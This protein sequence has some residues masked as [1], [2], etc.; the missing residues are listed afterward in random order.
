[1]AVSYAGLSGAAL[2][3]W[4]GSSSGVW[5]TASNW[6]PAAVPTTS[7][8]VVMTAPLHDA[9]FLLADTALIDSLTLGGGIDLLTNTKRLLV[10]DASEMAPLIMTDL[11]TVLNVLPH[12]TAGI[13]AV[14][15]DTLSVRN[16]AEIFLNGGIFDVDTHAEIQSTAKLRGHGLFKVNNSFTTVFTNDGLIEAEGGT[17]TLRSISGG[18]FNLSGAS[19]LGRLEITEG[20]SRLVI[21]AP[22]SGDFTGTMFI[23]DTNRV[24]LD[25]E[26]L[27][28]G[29]IV[30]FGSGQLRGAKFVNGGL[31][32][33]V[34]GDYTAQIFNSEI[35][36]NGQVQVFVGATLQ[37]ENTTYYTG[38]SYTDDGAMVHNAKFV[39]NSPT[40]VDIATFDLDGNNN[41]ITFTHEIN[42]DLTLNVD[43]IDLPN[44]DSSGPAFDHGINVTGHTE[45]AV[46]LTNPDDSWEMAGVMSLS[47]SD[48]Q[49]LAT[50]SGSK[51][52]MSG[53]MN[54]DGRALISAPLEITNGASITVGGSVT[55]R[56][57]LAGGPGQHLYDLKGG[58]IGGV[59]RLVLDAGAQLKGHG[60]IDTDFLSGGGLLAA[61]GGTLS[62]TSP[63]DLTG[64]VGTAD[65]TGTLALSQPLLNP[66]AVQI[67]GGLITAPRIE[68][69]HTRGR[70]QITVTDAFVV[71][72]GALIA[73]DGTL[74]V[75]SNTLAVEDSYLQAHNGKLIIDTANAPDLDGTTIA[76]NELRATTGDIQIIPA[77]TDPFNGL[78]NVG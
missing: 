36:M 38:G 5:G 28:D 30:F 49:H 29:S 16:Q 25:Q 77:V 20:D 31:I 39:V 19:G 48:F 3:T 26:F 66:A 57:T 54:T 65:P 44:N 40:T 73:L 22:Q 58:T 68:S 14:D 13:H 17:L 32:R 34:N 69:P 72:S 7:D 47:N 4:D 50:V 8:D 2:R 10:D 59:G 15:T 9:V 61:T 42:A 55:S 74:T 33:V 70:G 37:L 27:H 1:M 41:L 24:D 11:H 21:D 18:L 52:V 76:F 45:L 51:M 23:G 60:T 63:P 56:L 46:N 67:L 78:V 43:A 53:T 71:N 12:P 6:T 35:H 64:F 75:T 62:V